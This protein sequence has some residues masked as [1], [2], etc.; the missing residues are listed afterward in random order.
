MIL[1]VYDQEK[2]HDIVN[3]APVV[4]VSFLPVSVEDDPFPT[5]LPMLGCFGSFNQPGSNETAAPAIYLHGHVSSRFMKLQTSTRAED[6]GLPGIPVCV[7]ATYMDGLVLA[8]T[9]FNHS[10]NYRSAVVHGYASLVADPKEK[11]YGL[12][13]I[14][15][16]II[17]ERWANSRVPP[18]EAEMKS[19]SVIRV[20][21]VSASAKI[22]AAA[23]GNDKADL[24]DVEMRKKVWNGV[25]PAFLKYGEPIPGVE[26]MVDEVPPYL[27]R[28]IQQQNAES[29]AYATK[30]AT[31]KYP[32]K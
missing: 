27:K 26:N 4:H 30:V 6:E 28:W 15:D 29:E 3:G 10:C 14:T 7:A 11:M 5:I 21:V 12:E 8:L 19:T 2:I 22:R 31:N 20:D 23:A 17:S 16:N 18:T 9:P 25:I 32:S 24:E 1:A 13:L